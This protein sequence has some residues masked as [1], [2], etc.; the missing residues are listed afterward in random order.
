MNSLPIPRA[1]NS[2]PTKST[3]AAVM[4]SARCASAPCK[5][6]SVRAA[7][8][9]HDGVRLLSVEFAT[10]QQRAKHRN[11]RDGN[12]RCR[13]HGKRLGE[14]ERVK[15]LAFLTRQRKDRNEGEQDDRH[16]EEHGPSHQSCGVANSLPDAVAIAGVDTALLNESERVLR[17]HDAR[18]HEHAD[19]DGDAG[20]AHDVGGDA[21]VIH[22]E[23]R[24]EDGQRQ[25]KG[26][27]QDRSEVQQEDDVRQ[28]DEGNLLDQRGSQRVDRLLDQVRAVVERHDGDAS[29]QTGGDLRD[30]RFDG[31]DHFF[32]VHSGPRDDN[33]ANRLLCPLHERGDAERVSQLDIGH[34]LHINRELRSSRRRRSS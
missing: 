18:I 12:D 16:R 11:E 1:S 33:T 5:H 9:A 15:Q 24:H 32:R 7:E 6:R 23:E 29:W 2:A 4:V 34:L 19:R 8:D 14:R 26:D 25:R 22:A 21:G 10:E 17:D 30:A 28:R 13:E 20:E 3:A 31:V 27:D